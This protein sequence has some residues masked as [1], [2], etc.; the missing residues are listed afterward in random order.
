MTT[1]SNAGFAALALPNEGTLAKGMEG[2]M[3]TLAAGVLGSFFKP[4]NAGP[5][6]FPALPSSFN[7]GFGAPCE[8]PKAQMTATVG[9][10]GQGDID[11]GEGYSMHLNENSSE[12]TIKNANTGET[13]RIWGDP[14]VDVNGKHQ[15]DFWGTTTFQLGNGTKIT[16]NTEQW[17]GNPNA[18]V[19]KEL[20][21]TKGNQAIT[22]NGI[23]QNQLGDLSI[24]MGENGRRLDAAT[25][26]GYTLTEDK[27]GQGW[28]AQGTT[29][30]ATQDD[31]NA[32]AAGHQ[33]GPGS[34][35]PSLNEL[36][37]TFSQF[38]GFGI[39]SGALTAFA[40]ELGEA[41]SSK[42]QLQHHQRVDAGRMH[43]L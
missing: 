9:P 17:K 30:L 16:I 6:A 21:I 33:Y 10:N 8:P 12:I 32:T 34:T 40:I 4:L 39:M 28:I 42:P 13:T 1:I 14:H 22:V 24:T 37:Q 38:L 2:A 27:N 20:V 26:D 18:Y 5:L 7:I 43:A 3:L 35:A 23:S 41:V 19:A 11:L 15:F 25:R 31:L 36:R 29:R